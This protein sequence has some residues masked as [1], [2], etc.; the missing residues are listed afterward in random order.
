[1]PDPRAALAAS[2]PELYATIELERRRQADGIE[3]IASENYVSSAVLAA[4]G[5][6]LTNKYAEGYP[7]KRYYGGCEFVDV[8]ERMAIARARQ[9]FGAD[10]ANVQPHSGAQA[11]E[12][13]YLA[14]LKPGDK[15]LALKLDHGGHLTHGFHLNS[16]GKLYDFVHYGVNAET[17]R[18]DYDEVERLAQEH[19]PKLLLA[20]ASA[21]PRLWD[22]ARLRQI[23][24]GVGARLM[25]DMAHIAGL[26]AVDLHPDPVPFCD[27]VTT[28][29]HK[30][31]RGPRGGMILCREELAKEIDKAVFPGMQ[32]GPLMHIIAAKAVA[33]GEALRPEFRAYQQQVLD[34]AQALA[35]ALQSQGLRIVSG[36]TDNHLMLVDLGVLGAD[37][38]GNEITGKAVEKALDKSGIHC[39]KNM[40]PFD[41]KPALVT[42]GIRLGT[43]AATTRGLTTDDFIRV[44]KWIGDVAR[45]PFNEA[46]QERTRAE[47]A[48]LMAHYP[49]EA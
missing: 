39:N 32:G 46:L 35:G 13:V 47:V 6:V 37:A 25:M 29:T 23:A 49:V 30:T 45:E 48:E 15:V 26:V 22:F 7:G 44:G 27:V 8:A 3:L 5:S 20:G 11:N 38:Q 12:A 18:I 21:Y 42:S 17:E 10:H 1:M 24:D 40:I 14:L 34:N 2:D 36:G 43:P 19:H 16:S 4:M 28:T 41:P 9:L 31:L 33:F